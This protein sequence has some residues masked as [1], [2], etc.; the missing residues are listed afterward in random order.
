MAKRKTTSK[1]SSIARPL[2]QEVLDRQRGH[3]ADFDRTELEELLVRAA[4]KI[5][6]IEGRLEELEAKNRVYLANKRRPT[7]ARWSKDQRTH[8]KILAQ[9][10]FEAN[11]ATRIHERGARASFIK[12]MSEAHHEIKDPKSFGLWWDAWKRALAKEL[13][14][15]Q[16]TPLDAEDI[17]RWREW[18]ESL[19]RLP[20]I[21]KLLGYV[22]KLPVLK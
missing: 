7:D 12:S 10:A 1:F 17:R 14:S 20:T 21:L 15:S 3:F 9:K 2:G 8:I 6:N 19:T 16:G 11:W 4:H 5:E 13:A 18:M 22:P